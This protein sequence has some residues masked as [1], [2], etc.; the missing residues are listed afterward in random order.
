MMVGLSLKSGEFIMLFEWIEMIRI[1]STTPSARV[2]IFL[3]LYANGGAYSYS[4]HKKICSTSLSL[5]LQRRTGF[6]YLC[7]ADWCRGARQEKVWIFY[8]CHRMLQPDLSSP[9]FLCKV[10]GVWME[11]FPQVRVLLR[12]GNW[13]TLTCSWVGRCHPLFSGLWNLP[14]WNLPSSPSLGINF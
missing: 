14:S 6:P 4:K 5:L 7:S 12:T 9:P 2:L 8:L 3:P 10:W 13:T 1:C 11:L